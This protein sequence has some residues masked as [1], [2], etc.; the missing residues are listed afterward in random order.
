MD[1]CAYDNEHK[2]HFAND[3]A[4]SK[5]SGRVDKKAKKNDDA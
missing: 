1:D 3:I 5:R 4:L 2:G